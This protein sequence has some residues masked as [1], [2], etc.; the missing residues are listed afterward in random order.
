MEVKHICETCDAPASKRCAGCSRAWY[1]SKRCQ[2]ELW[3]YHIFHCNPN[4]P[5]KTSY[6]IAR[7][8]RRDE[9]PEDP[10]TLEDHGFVRAVSTMEKSRLLGLYKGLLMFTDPKTLHKWRV[11]GTL[12][13]EIKAVFDALPPGRRGGYYPWFLENQHVLD[14]SIPLP[15]TPEDMVNNGLLRAWSQ[16]DE[17]TL[18]S[19]YR[20]LIHRC[21]FRDL[22]EAYEDSK[23]LDFM[24]SHG[25][26]IEH[27]FPYLEKFLQSSMRE[28]VWWLKQLVEVGN[29][30]EY[31]TEPTVAVDYGFDKCRPGTD[32]YA[33][34]KAL[35]KQVLDMPQARPLDLHQACIQG[36]LYDYVTKFVAI[37]GR[38][39]RKQ[40]KRMLKNPYPLACL[41]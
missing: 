33:N 18:G 39:S 22:V 12:V 15:V 24:R 21:T 3:S 34:L 38:D 5:I 8:I 37:K 2:E 1:C 41:D 17:R 36:K 32:D 23:L 29:A 16:Y 10:Q 31:Q 30:D 6:Y 19:L 9:L 25:L 27:R 20:Q 40:F 4:K 7:A 11:N 14:R 28:S 26:Q 35:Y 13:K